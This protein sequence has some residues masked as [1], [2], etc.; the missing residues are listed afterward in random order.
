[1]RGATEIGYC[2]Y[3][4][5]QRLSGRGLTKSMLIVIDVVAKTEILKWPCFG[6]I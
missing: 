6:P 3:K 4:H 1:M 5:I 2:V